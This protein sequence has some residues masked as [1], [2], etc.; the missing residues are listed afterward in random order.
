MPDPQYSSD[1]DRALSPKDEDR[2]ADV[3][4]FGTPSVVN[5]QLLDMQFSE[6]YAL[7][8]KGASYAELNQKLSSIKDNLGHGE[9]EEI[10]EV[11]KEISC[12]TSRGCDTSPNSH[13]LA[14]TPVTQSIDFD[15]TSSHILEAIDLTSLNEKT[16]IFCG[17]VYFKLVPFIFIVYAVFVTNAERILGIIMN[18][19]YNVFQYVLKRIQEHWETVS[20]NCVR[21]GYE[22]RDIDPGLSEHLKQ[23]NEGLVEKRNSEMGRLQSQTSSPSFCSW[24]KFALVPR[25]HSCDIGED[26]PSLA[27]TKM[28]GD[29]TGSA[30]ISKG[31]SSAGSSKLM[32]AS[33]DSEDGTPISKT[34]DQAPE[35]RARENRAT[36]RLSRTEPLK[37]GA[38]EQMSPVVSNY[39][40]EIEKI[41]KKEG[42]VD[43]Q[44]GDNMDKE[45]NSQCW[46]TRNAWSTHDRWSTYDRWS[47]RDQ[48]S[49]HERFLEQSQQGLVPLFQQQEPDTGNGTTSDSFGHK[50]SFIQRDEDEA[51]PP[52]RRSSAVLRSMHMLRTTVARTGNGLGGLAR[53]VSLTFRRKTAADPESRFISGQDMRKTVTFLELLLTE[54]HACEIRILARRNNVTKLRCV[55][56]FPVGTSL[57]TKF[58]VQ[59]I[60]AFMCIVFMYRVR[61]RKATAASEH[62]YSMFV[63]SIHT[64]FCETTGTEVP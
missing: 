41:R 6:E 56:H 3:G 21:A 24:L 64:S 25:L 5:E 42:V 55:K 50:S 44:H 59:P 48:W 16:D 46:E 34:L 12:S 49:V 60:D 15:R 14:G 2:F 28:S 38:V 27:T 32:C 43:G 19:L 33:P 11:G 7:T 47:T 26:Q 1:A 17:T 35:L 58:V 63:N 23:G 20:N 40:R 53:R 57:H 8:A 30:H 18:F 54:Q 61:E 51:G 31:R 22:G 13:S 36:I 9:E 37:V 39:V 52:L 45:K 4:T 29:G 62:D 10:H